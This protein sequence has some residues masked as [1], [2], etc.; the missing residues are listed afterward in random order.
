MTI[1]RG[2]QT[3][4][5]TAD[6]SPLSEKTYMLGWYFF[7]DN[8][9]IIQTNNLSNIKD[10]LLKIN[11]LNDLSKKESKENFENSKSLFSSNLLDINN[12]KFISDF[13]D[14]DKKEA[15]IKLKTKKSKKKKIII[16]LVMMRIMKIILMII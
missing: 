7:L 1:I 11:N 15:E 3:L 4:K 8:K 9:E 10:N 12:Y 14:K 5:Q 13:Q 16:F 2:S 6:Y